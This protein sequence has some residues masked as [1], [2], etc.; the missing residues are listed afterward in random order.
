MVFGW[1]TVDVGT[2]TGGAQ[3]GGG[4]HAED[5]YSGTETGD[6][7]VGGVTSVGVG[8]VD[9]VGMSGWYGGVGAETVGRGSA[10]VVGKA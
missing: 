10:R 2:E 7:Q 9:R 4:P 5:G 8:V 3:L 1:G 6:T